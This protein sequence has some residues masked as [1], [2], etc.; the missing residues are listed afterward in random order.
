VA[1]EFGFVGSLGE[2]RELELVLGRDQLALDRARVCAA[3]LRFGELLLEAFDSVAEGNDGF[4][5]LSE[6]LP[7]RR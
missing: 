1:F 2:A 4:A 6:P 5:C 7:Y 3:L